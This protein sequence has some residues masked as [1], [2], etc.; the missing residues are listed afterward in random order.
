MCKENEPKTCCKLARLLGTLE[1]TISNYDSQASNYFILIEKF[2]TELFRA[3]PHLQLNNFLRS[4]RPNTFEYSR[5][6][7]PLHE[8]NIE[9]EKE[10]IWSFSYTVAVEVL[11]QLYFEGFES[12]IFTAF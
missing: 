5:A 7:N 6:K 12:F 10:H 11:L 3:L 4:I 2:P 8:L 9:I 1:Q